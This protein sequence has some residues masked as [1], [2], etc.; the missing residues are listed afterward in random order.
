MPTYEFR[1]PKGHEF[2]KFYR[3]IGSAPA[4]VACPV[5]GSIAERQLSAGGGLVFKGSGFYITDYGKDGKKS[6]TPPVKAGDTTPAASGSDSGSKS[7]TGGKVES[8]P[9]VE[10]K[11]ATEA[12][13]APPSKSAAKS[14]SKREKG[15]E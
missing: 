10:S 14:T 3:S 11:P 8:K 9:S 4:E 15:S 5:C 6:Q 2:E 13:P 7:D 1:C 12:K